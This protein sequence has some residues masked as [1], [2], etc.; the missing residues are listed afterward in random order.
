ML[1][2]EAYN[3]L[4]PPSW[5]F[6]GEEEIMR[7]VYIS[8]RCMFLKKRNHHAPEIAAKHMKARTQ[9]ADTYYNLSV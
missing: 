9:V 3:M 6:T 4:K 1:D 5:G 7:R 8:T 2:Q